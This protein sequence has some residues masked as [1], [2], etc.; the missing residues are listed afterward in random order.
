MFSCVLSNVISFVNTAYDN[1]VNEVPVATILTGI[2]MPDHAA[3]FGTLVTELKYQVTPHVA[4]LKAQDCQN[5]KNLVENM[6][7]QFVNVIE[8]DD[9]SEDVRNKMGSS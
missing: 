5:L 9:E 8:N 7:D 6:V 3:Q 2:N 1:P 4:S